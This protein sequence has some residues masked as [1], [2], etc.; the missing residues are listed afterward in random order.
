VSRQFYKA[1]SQETDDDEGRGV[2][3]IDT[4]PLVECVAVGAD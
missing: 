1:L 4:A 3:M 2:T